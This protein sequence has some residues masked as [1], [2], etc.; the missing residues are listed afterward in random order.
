MSAATTTDRSAEVTAPKM[1][2]WV[3]TATCACARCLVEHG[4]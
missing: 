1:P 3:H 4:R 2:G